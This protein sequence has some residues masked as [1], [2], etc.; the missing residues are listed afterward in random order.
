ML[1]IVGKEK[2]LKAHGCIIQLIFLCQI[3]Y[4]GSWNNVDNSHSLLAF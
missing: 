4:P 1:Q 2:I 3:T